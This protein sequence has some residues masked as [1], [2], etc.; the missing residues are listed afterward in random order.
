MEEKSPE[1][2][3]LIDQLESIVKEIVSEFNKLGQEMGTK[4][5]VN[6]FIQRKFMSP[7][8][9]RLTYVPVLFDFSGMG[10]KVTRIEDAEELELDDK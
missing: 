5:L 6:Y 10:F 2:V 9:K 8:E 7:E 3:K 4:I 1:I